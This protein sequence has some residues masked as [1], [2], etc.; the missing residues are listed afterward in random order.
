MRL[1]ALCASGRPF[2]AVTVGRA[3]GS[4]HSH[5]TVTVA[6][7]PALLREDALAQLPC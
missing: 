5:A 2:D 7:I 6:R 4:A 3:A 1:L